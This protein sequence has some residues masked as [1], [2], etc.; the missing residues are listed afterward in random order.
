MLA[1][2]PKPT[3]TPLRALSTNSARAKRSMTPA[4]AEPAPPPTTAPSETAPRSWDPAGDGSPRILAETF[5]EMVREG[6]RDAQDESGDTLLLLPRPFVLP[7][8]PLPSLSLL[9]VPPALHRSIPPF[10]AVASLSLA[11]SLPHPRISILAAA[12]RDVPVHMNRVPFV[13]VAV[14][15]AWATQLRHSAAAG[16]DAPHVVYMHARGPALL[17]RIPAF[18]GPGPDQTQT[19]AAREDQPYPSPLTSALARKFGL[20]PVLIPP[21]DLAGLAAVAPS[22]STPS[23]NTDR[24]KS[25][26]P[27]PPSE[28]HPSVLLLSHCESSFSLSEGCG[29]GPWGMYLGYTIGSGDQTDTRAA[30]A[31]EVWEVREGATVLVPSTPLPDDH[32]APAPTPSFCLPSWYTHPPSGVRHISGLWVLWELVTA[33]ALSREEDI[34]SRLEEAEVGLVGEGTDG[35]GVEGRRT[36]AVT[37][38]ARW[39]EVDHAWVV[40]NG[41]TLSVPQSAVEVV[42]TL[43]HVPTPYDPYTHQDTTLADLWRELEVLRAW[44]AIGDDEEELER[45]RE[46][47]DGGREQDENDEEEPVVQWTRPAEWC[48]WGVEVGAGDAV[49]AWLQDTAPPE[50]N[51]LDFTD[52]LWRFLAFTARDADDLRDAVTGVAEEIER[53]RCRPSVAKSNSTPL[54]RAVRDVLR[55]TALATA[56]AASLASLRRRAEAG[57]D[58]AVE[59]PFSVMSECGRWRVGRALVAILVG[60]GMDRTRVDPYLDQGLSPPILLANYVHLHRACEAARL[61]RDAAA[62]VPEAVVRRVVGACLARRRPDDEPDVGQVGPEGVVLEVKLGRW[63]G[64]ARMVEVVSGSIQPSVWE[65]ALYTSFKPYAGYVPRGSFPTT[66]TAG[67]TFRLERSGYEGATFPE[68]KKKDVDEW[69]GAIDLVGDNTKYMVVEAFRKWVGY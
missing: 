35:G 6:T 11:P 51:D 8:S 31:E 28:T 32:D 55:V 61:L 24:R 43:H 23:S 42:V 53:G 14:D 45:W 50:E 22:S 63:D 49:D 39:K 33:T 52:R 16:A 65:L 41:G 20:L 48:G 18:A 30:G 10:A 9:L 54:A 29:D 25:T 38:S 5:V 67:R 64:G 15:A 2:T 59:K 12:P 27:N 56:P 13:Q 3:K 19:Q 58:E 46:S 44:T 4:K 17:D 60:L 57:F 21:R 68:Q 47:R 40:A 1:T 7:P 62:G 66:P 37:L 36:S 34:E 69:G 26:L